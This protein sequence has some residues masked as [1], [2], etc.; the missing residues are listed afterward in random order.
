MCESI[1]FIAWHVIEA[2]LEVSH[3]ILVADHL[4]LAL[5]SSELNLGT[6]ALQIFYNPC[7]NW[8]SLI[9]RMLSS[10]AIIY[11]FGE[12]GVGMGVRVV[13]LKMG[14]GHAR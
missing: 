12:F 5:N 10:M 2:P 8:H 3:L 4:C 14:V 7:Q 6:R 1:S 13:D 11:E 9:Q